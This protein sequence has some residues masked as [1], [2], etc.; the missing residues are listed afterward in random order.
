[1]L[2][3]VLFIKFKCI[4]TGIQSS[5]CCLLLL[6]FF[7]FFF[8]FGSCWF[9]GREN[10]I[11]DLLYSLYTIC[12]LFINPFS[13]FT[14]GLSGNIRTPGYVRT[15]GKTKLFFPLGSYI[16]C[17]VF[18]INSP[19][20]TKTALLEGFQIKEPLISKSICFIFYKTHL[21]IVTKVVQ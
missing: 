3:H 1:M 17:I 4:P 21:S 13:R 6:F 2:A 18:K 19:I 9:Y 8:F 10:F 11:K 15:L 7:F 16:K 20:E 5:S 14:S 12:T